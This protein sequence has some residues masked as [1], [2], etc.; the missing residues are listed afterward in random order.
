MLGRLLSDT[1]R[2]SDVPDGQD[3]YFRATLGRTSVL[4][5]LGFGGR[6]GQ[7]PHASDTTISVGL[8]VQQRPP[9]TF[10]SSGLDVTATLLA[11][12]FTLLALAAGLALL[13]ALWFAQ[14]DTSDE[15]DTD[16]T[17]SATPDPTADTSGYR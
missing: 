5:S 16:R 15:S 4:D 14:F 3:P 11:G 6:F 2:W 17:S 7:H 9:K 12:W 13:A 8:I 10:G 1:I